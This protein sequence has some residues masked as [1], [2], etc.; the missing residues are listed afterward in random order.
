VVSIP[1]ARVDEVLVKSAEREADE[2][3]KIARIVAGERT[4][5]IYGWGP[6]G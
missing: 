5:D 6:G 1:Q 3:A 2:A 4:I